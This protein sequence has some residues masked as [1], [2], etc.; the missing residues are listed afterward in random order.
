[1]PS[2]ASVAA[3]LAGW[4]LGAEVAGVVGLAV[5]LTGLE[6][7]YR[8]LWLS[9]ERCR[10]RDEVGLAASM[11][12]PPSAYL[13]GLFAN[14]G[15]LASFAQGQLWA[16]PLMA[17]GLSRLDVAPSAQW[18]VLLLGCWVLPALLAGVAA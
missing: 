5:A 15:T 10:W 9:R 8:S 17:W 3:L 1:M 4:A 18:G 2:L 7:R 14:Q 16:A 12:I 11:L 13:A 6:C